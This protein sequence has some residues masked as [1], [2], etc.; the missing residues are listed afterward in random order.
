MS[1]LYEY[2]CCNDNCGWKGIPA[3][4]HGDTVCGKCLSKRIVLTG[5]DAEEEHKGQLKMF[6]EMYPDSITDE[7]IENDRVTATEVRAVAQ[8][9]G[10]SALDVQVGG[11]HYRDRGIQPIQFILANELGFCEGNV[12]KYVTRHKFKNGL[13]DL[14]KARHYIDFLIEEYKDEN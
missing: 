14:K 9:I 5:K 4:L 7:V 6:Y 10:K 12:V 1:K 3:L 2:E 8:E 11:S 13:E